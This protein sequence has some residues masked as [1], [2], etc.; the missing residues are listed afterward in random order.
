MFY[1][2][3]FQI[4]KIYQDFTIVN[5]KNNI[6]CFVIDI[7]TILA[8]NHSCFLIDIGP[9]SMILEISFDDS[10]SFVGARLFA[11]SQHFGFQNVEI[12]NNSMFFI[13]WD[14]LRI[15]WSLSLISKGSRGR[16][17]VDFL[18]VSRMSKTCWNMSGSLN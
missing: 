6:W 14:F 10:L 18:E 15:F 5:F 9:I 1:F 17:L 13:V 12:R 4:S 16:H 11:N 8:K 3:Y 7:G 2:L